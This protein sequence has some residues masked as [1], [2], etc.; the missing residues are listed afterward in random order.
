M[1]KSALRF[2]HDLLTETI[3]PGDMVVDAT[4]GNGND[5]V[6]MAKLVG[7]TGHVFGF[8]IQQQ[9]IDVTNQKLLLTG[10]LPQTTLFHMGH[11][12]LGIV[13]PK[14]TR[15]AAAIFNLGYLP[16]GDKTITTH[17]KTTL[18]AVTELLPRLR[19]GGIVILVV[20]YG[21]KNG[22][23]E[24]EAIL[25]W[26]PTLSQVDY[27]VLCYSFLNQQNDPPFLLAVQKK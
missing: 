21:H 9:A 4:V 27:D 1:L 13:I 11:E 15:I 5:T 22:M 7:P 6:L 18:T 14:N 26:A 25:E 2:S 10:L 19:K 12:N 24:K 16:A 3:M 23:Q 17:S 8:D 20:Y